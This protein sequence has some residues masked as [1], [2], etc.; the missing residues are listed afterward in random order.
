M[1]RRFLRVRRVQIGVGILAVF[2]L[3]AVFG[4]LFTSEVLRIEPLD[5]DPQ[6]LGMPPSPAHLLGTT[7]SGQDAL[8]WM[9]HGTRSSIFVGAVSALVGTAIALV[10]G[11]LAG[12][13]GGWVDRAI[14][15]FILVFNTTPTFAILFMVAAI[16]PS[17]N[18]LTVAIIIGLLEWSGGARAIRAQALSL[19]SRQFTT[20]LTTAG[21]SGWRIIFS[22]L[23]PHLFGVI[24]P[25]VLRLVSAGITFQAAIAFLGIGDAAE[26]SWGLMIQYAMSQ[27]AL[28]TGL[29]WWFLPPGLA[30]AMIGFATTLINFGLDEVT[31]PTLSSKRRALTR[32]YREQVR[33]N[34]R[35]P[36]PEPS[37]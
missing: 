4:P 16:F 10:T 12:Y 18:L 36:V 7:S 34:P 21:E 25:M 31:N 6:A 20:A 24:S 22:E 28:Y 33:L 14:N 23:V 1:P 13:C 3:V 26:P 32:R 35:R 27:N 17:A 8:V 11:L 2:V 9:I 15:A 29:W 30:I 19:R 37:R 5:I